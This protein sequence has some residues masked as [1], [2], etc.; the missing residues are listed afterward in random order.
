MSVIPQVDEIKVD[1]WDGCALK[2]A[3]DDVVRKIFT[4]DLKYTEKNMFVDI[5]L[6]FSTLGCGV[7]LYA[8][9][10]DYLYPF[11]L[12]KV[13]LT[14]CVLLYFTLM[15]LLT[16][17]MTFVEK[18]I[19]IVSKQKEAAGLDP[20]SEWSVK[21]SLKRFDSGYAVEISKKDGT[22]KQSSHA[23]FSK[24]VSSWVN[25]DGVILVDKLKDDVLSCHQDIVNGVAGG[26]K[27]Q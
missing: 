1:K 3:L 4:D 12:S 18:N 19:I 26:K 6:A 25:V 17:F 16:V 24:C 15:S 7:A 23:A 11:P 14:V 20:D 9:L 10:Y 8:L 13:V 22:T 2:N 5:R 27:D 21:T